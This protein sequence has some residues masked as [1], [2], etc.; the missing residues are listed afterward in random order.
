MQALSAE[1]AVPF[2]CLDFPGT[3]DSGLAVENVDQGGNDLQFR[4]VL[5]YFD[6]K[7]G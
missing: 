7:L 1:K 5:K 3:R 4:E 2:P 6:L